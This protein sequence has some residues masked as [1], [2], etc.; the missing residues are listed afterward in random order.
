[1]KI[2]GIIIAGIMAAAAMPAAAEFRWGPT[3]GT[4]V[5]SFSWRQDLVDTRHKFGFQAGVMGEIMI[6]GIGFG[7]DLGVRYNQH[8]A[9]VNFGERP[10]WSLDGYGD[11]SIMIRS[12]QIPL[13]LRF[14]WTRL[15]GFEHYAAPFVY[16][17]PVFSF[18]MSSGDCEA[19][20]HP[21]GTIGIQ[22]GGGVELFEHWQLSGGYHFGVAYEVRTVKLDNFSARSNGWNINLTY[23]F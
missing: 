10:I 17:G 11:E 21:T 22:V 23:L 15:D 2:K 4:D 7:I 1:M 6:P 18:I 3:A 16:A 14:K 8:G 13:D 12:I 9:D 19:V 5:S 20:E